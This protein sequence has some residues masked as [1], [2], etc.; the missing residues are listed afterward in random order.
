[1]EETDCSFDI[2]AK[3]IFLQ[4]LNSFCRLAPLA[5]PECLTV[6]ASLLPTQPGQQ[7]RTGLTTQ[8][9]DWETE[10]LRDITD[11]QTLNQSSPPPSPPPASPVCSGCGGAGG[12]DGRS[13]VLKL[14]LQLS[15]WLVG[16]L[17]SHFICT[18]P[19]DLQDQVAAGGPA[20]SLAPSLSLSLLTSES[21]II[22]SFRKQLFDWSVNN[23]PFL[24]LSKPPEKDAWNEKI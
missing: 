24:F 13:E 5:W 6:H 12:V 20:Q 2:L 22:F 1:M 11:Y 4:G 17:H 21:F 15:H 3:S 16:N 19:R 9:G 7:S 14:W 10:R 18:S 23:S 8:L